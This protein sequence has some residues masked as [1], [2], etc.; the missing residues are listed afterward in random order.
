MA[1]LP[2]AIYV[3]NKVNPYQ[4]SNDILRRNRKTNHEIYIETQRPQVAKAILSKTS[5]AGGITTPSFKRYY[6]TITIKTA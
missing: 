4:N 1:I 6:R 2:K 5:N 3:S